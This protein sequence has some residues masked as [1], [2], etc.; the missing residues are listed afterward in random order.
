MRPVASAKDHI[1][2]TFLTGAFFAIPLAITLFIIYWINLHTQPITQFFFGRD[3]PLLGVVIALGVIYLI[4]MIGNSLVGSLFLRTVDR[5]ISHV[6]MVG[7]VYSSWKQIALT[8]GGTEGTFSKVVV[9]PD[10]SGHMKWLGFTSGRVVAAP[11]PCF[12]VFVPNAPNPITGRLYFVPVGKCTILAMS[13]EDAFKLILSTGN[14]VPAFTNGA[15]PIY[16]DEKK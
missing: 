15:E 10:E 12:C 5:I 4:G 14:Y 3:I 1:R 11:E 8:P 13:A 6:P 2:K 16:M 7:Q 9:L